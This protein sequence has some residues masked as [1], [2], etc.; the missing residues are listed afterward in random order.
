MVA[1]ALAAARHAREAAAAQVAAERQ[2]IAVDLHDTIGQIL[3][4]IGASAKRSGVLAEGGNPT[5]TANMKFIEAEA[6]RAGAHL[7]EIIRTIARPAGE[8]E[9]E[10]E[11]RI[12][13]EMFSARTGIAADVVVSGSR[14]PLSHDAFQALA[15]VVREALH[16]VEKHSRAQTV[17]V[18]L[19]FDHERISVVV[20]DDGIGL[21]RP[22]RSGAEPVGP[23]SGIGLS[24]LLRRLDR[25]GGQLSGRRL[26]DG[27][28]VISATLDTGEG[29]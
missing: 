24:S 20:Q 28:T 3:F 26:P 6:S 1:P 10:T 19:H 11:V 16:N 8:V 22:V 17:V 21:P 29:E 2:R 18:T 7:R 14:R 12:L 25:L 13:T 23:G 5:L 4:G 15:A 27:G 9:L